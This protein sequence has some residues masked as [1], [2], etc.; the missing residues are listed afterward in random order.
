MAV[1]WVVLGASAEGCAT[2]TLLLLQLL[3]LASGGATESCVE[4]RLASLGGSERSAPSDCE[5]LRSGV[6]KDTREPSSAETKCPLL[7]SR[8]TSLGASGSKEEEEEVSKG[9]GAL[10]DFI[11]V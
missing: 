9:A 2:G 3:L 10:A 7:G 8:K 4:E 5:A 11:E 6:S 1:T